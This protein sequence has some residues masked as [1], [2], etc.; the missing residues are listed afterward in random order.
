M[1]NTAFIRIQIHLFAICVCLAMLVDTQRHM[2]AGSSSLRLFRTLL[3]VCILLLATESASWFFHGSWKFFWNTVCFSLHAVPGYF[4]SQYVDV[5]LGFGEEDLRRRRL[6]RLLP[7]LLSESLIFVNLFTPILFRIDSDGLYRRESLFFL[8]TIISYSYLVYT[9]IRIFLQRRHLDRSI[10]QPLLFF[11]MIPLI[12]VN[13]QLYLYGTGFAWP[14][15]ALA[16]LVCYI[17]IQNRQLGT[18]YLTS[19][20]N[21]LQ[22]DQQL[23]CRC[24]NAAKHPFSAIMIDINGFKAINDIH[25]HLVGDDALV[26]TVALLR[27]ALR[28]NDFLARYGGDEFLILTDSH[29]KEDL[30]MMANR[31]KQHFQCFNQHDAK[32][33]KLNLSIGCAVYD[34][35]KRLT[36]EEFLSLVDDRMY[37][38]KQAAI[39][40]PG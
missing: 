15:V 7:L 26:Q 33:Y 5:Q 31:I 1:E 29:S 36:P 11:H 12:G 13:A 25:G 2:Q 18:D 24:Q 17:Y 23:R 37:K 14:S 9:L 30:E 8:E 16:L 6:E 27:Q 3:V 4:F 40:C 32:P 39:A 22:V 38:E 20:S 34:P 10:L 28:R 35:D 21:R 19:A